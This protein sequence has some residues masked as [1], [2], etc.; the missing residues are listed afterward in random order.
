MKDI[1][2]F[3]GNN[4][5]FMADI[6]EIVRNLWGQ[7]TDVR[8]KAVIALKGLPREATL[9]ELHDWL[10]SADD[11]EKASILEAMLIL[12]CHSAIHIVLP[13]LDYP[14]G[15]LRRHICG[16]LMDYGNSKAVNPLIQTARKDPEGYVR[17][18]ACE[19]LAVNGDITSIEVLQFIASTDVGEDS[20]GIPIRDYALTAI[21]TINKRYFGTLEIQP[22]CV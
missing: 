21:D 5:A 3:H 4:S 11:E 13:F 16:L 1:D 22:G 14:V 17:A 8:E 7:G 15:W 6:Q 12:D 20:Q 9:L 19:A 18:M 10:I 2:M